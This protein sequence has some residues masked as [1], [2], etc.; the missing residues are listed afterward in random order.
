[1]SRRLFLASLFVGYALIANAHAAQ[2]WFPGQ[3]GQYHLIPDGQDVQNLTLYGGPNPVCPSGFAL[4]AIDENGHKDTVPFVV[5]S[6]TVF[7]LT[8]AL[9]AGSVGG[10][11]TY[12]GETPIL[13]IGQ[14]TLNSYHRASFLATKALQGSFAE[15]FE[16]QG[17]LQSGAVFA[18]GETLCAQAT[19]YPY[20]YQAASPDLNLVAIQIH[21]K[22]IDNSRT[23]TWPYLT[24]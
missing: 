15:G 6:R 22:V 23:A 17:S 11:S 3:T 1:M 12:P 20:L 18:T 16:G 7:V 13:N 2:D 19:F 5:P 21:G 9:F 14:S 24:W 4:F 8:D 10:G